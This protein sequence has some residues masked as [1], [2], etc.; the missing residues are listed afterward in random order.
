MSVDPAKFAALQKILTGAQL[1]ALPQS[2]IRVLELS[3]DENNGPAEYSLP[4]EADPGLTAQ[5]LKFVNSS[6]FGFAH[7]IASVRQAIA[8]VGVRTIKNF[9]LWNAVFSLM[10]NPRNGIFDLKLLWQDSLQRAICARNVGKMMR[11]REAEDVFAAALLQDMAIPILAKELGK[12]YAAL[13][14]ARQDGVARLSALEFERYG[15]THAVAAVALAGQW[16]LPKEMV[17]LIANHTLSLEHET[18]LA[19][20]RTCVVLSSLL[21]ASVD[22]GWPDLPAFEELYQRISGPNTP[23][24]FELLC[25]IDH[26]FQEFAPVLKLSSTGRTLADRYRTATATVA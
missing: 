17:E 2:A 19:Q 25:E 3:R 11:L 10:P 15:W 4:L 22:Q 21:P 1:P 6:Y 23:P 8:L 14:A 18:N 20:P 26:S 7:E 13:L 5:I 16:K 24:M 9:V 12:D